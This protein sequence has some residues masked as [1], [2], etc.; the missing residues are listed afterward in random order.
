[1]AADGAFGFSP[2]TVY[3]AEIGA[4]GTPDTAWH[5]DGSAGAFTVSTADELAGLAELVNAGNRF[6]GKTVTL[7]GDIDLS[8]YG[9]GFNGGKGWTP[10]GSGFD[11]SFSGH[12]N[13]NHYAISNLY[14]NDTSIGYA[15]LLGRVDGGTVTN[16]QVTGEITAAGFT[17]G[18][19]GNLHNGD[20]SSCGFQG[21]IH[22]GEDGNGGIAGYTSGHVSNCSFDGSISVDTFAGGIVGILHGGSVTDCF[23]S[24]AVAARN[25][26]AGG[27]VSMFTGNAA[28]TRNYSVTQVSG[29]N[30][31][32]GIVGAVVTNTLQAAALSLSISGNYALNASVTATGDTAS[33][34]ITGGIALGTSNN[35][36]LDT[37]AGAWS[38]K[39]SI[40]KDGLDITALEA[41][42]NGTRKDIFTAQNGWTTQNGFLPGLFG[43]PAALPAHIPVSPIRLT[44]A[45]SA[46]SAEYTG[47]EIIPETMTVEIEGKTVTLD[48]DTDFEIAAISDNTNAGTASLTVHFKSLFTGSAVTEFAITRAGGAGTVSLN[49][50]TFNE[51]PNA[52]AFDGVTAEYRTP[53][54]EYKAQDADD[55]AYTAEVPVNAGNYTVR[56]LWAQTANYAEHVAE[57]NFTIRKRTPDAADLRFAIPENHI[58]NGEI[59]GIGSV[60]GPREFGDIIISY[61]GSPQKPVGAGT[62]TITAEVAESENYT[63]AL[64]TLGTYTIGA[65]PAGFDTRW[66]ILII[67]LPALLAVVCAAIAIAREKRKALLAPAPENMVVPV[68]DIDAAVAK[69]MTS[70]QHYAFP[71]D[72]TGREREVARLIMRGKSIR[73]MMKD[74]TVTEATVKKHIG[75]VLEKGGCENQKEF[76]LK[77]RL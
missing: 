74:L 37:M 51:S 36:A 17:G 11:H 70:G 73:E 66:F 22:G 6:D 26:Y 40:G 25:D 18:I 34:R 64:L 5:G 53:A 23:S 39:G 43:T 27:I 32:G 75:N 9:A 71:E 2:V 68:T 59:Q 77:Y 65:A 61:S 28:V 42:S 19:V 24:G 56:A 52:P 33:G 1:M 3:A 49:G 15:G 58:Y 12:F 10:I 48:K 69:A 14:I 29:Q 35:Y 30:N 16:V 63:G 54:V 50:W 41:V 76:I 47:G 62:Y 60:E 38:G 13:G 20:I 7:A 8:V 57:A 4:T 44:A 72:L 67:G 55:T 45:V 46:A 31:V 21:N